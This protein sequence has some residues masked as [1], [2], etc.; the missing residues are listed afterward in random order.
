MCSSFLSFFSRSRIINLRKKIKCSSNHKDIIIYAICML[1]G[2]LYINVLRTSPT[3]WQRCHAIDIEDEFYSDNF[4]SVV[5][6]DVERNFADS[7]AVRPGFFFGLKRWKREPSYNLLAITLYL[8]RSWRKVIVHML[9]RGR[10]ALG[11]AFSNKLPSAVG[12]TARF[13]KPAALC[14]QCLLILLIS[15]RYCRTTGC[16]SH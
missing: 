7:T 9:F 1:Y 2:S 11:L 8:G 13:F 6:V 10:I 4:L 16:S 12:T 14:A 3:A 15:I 5:V